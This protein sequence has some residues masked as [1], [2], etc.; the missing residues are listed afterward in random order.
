MKPGSLGLCT[1]LNNLA[2]AY[3]KQEQY[4]AALYFYERAVDVLNVGSANGSVAMDEQRRRARDHVMGKLAR[5]PRPNRSTSALIEDNDATQEVVAHMWEEVRL[6]RAG[7]RR[8]SRDLSSSPVPCGPLALQGLRLFVADRPDDALELF[9]HVLTF[10][11]KFRLDDHA[12][13]ATT[14]NNIGATHEKRRDLELAASYFR[15][16]IE[17]LEKSSVPGKDPKIEHVRARLA[18]VSP[19]DAVA[20]SG[21]RLNERS[22]S[23]SSASTSRLTS[24]GEKLRIEAVSDHLPALPE[25]GP[26]VADEPPPIPLQDN[27]EVAE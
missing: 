9:E 13:V 10:N 20:R 7:R 19:D 21:E 22:S 12:V 6:S 18:V 3:D 1:N 4:D 26:A 27:R 17:T 11:R 24:T 5:M 15:A 23:S 14:L 2:S 8:H 25:E 16:A